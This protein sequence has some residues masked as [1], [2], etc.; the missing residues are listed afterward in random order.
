MTDQIAVATRKG[1]FLLQRRSPRNWEI[2]HV[3]FLGDAFA[4]VEPDPRDNSLY[5]A[6]NLGHFGVKLFRSADGG[7]DWTEIA[8]PAYPAPPADAPP[9]VCRMSGRPIPWKL[10]LV[11]SLAPGGA[12]QPGVLWAGTLPGGLFRSEDSGRSW[13]LVRSLWDRPERRQWTGG[14]YDYAGIHSVCVDPRDSRRVTL[15]VSTGGVWRTCDGGA[16]W[17]L[18]GR[19][20]FA[21][22]L[23]PD[24]REDPGAQDVHRLAACRAAP[25]AMWVQHHNGIFRS[26][27][28]ATTFSHVAGVKP[29][30][31]GFAVAAHP[32]DPA[33]AW[34]V[35]AVKDEKRIPVDGRLV[36]T[37][38]RDGGRTFNAL[39]DGLP[40]EPSYDLVYRHCL[41]VD[42]TGSRLVM[43]STTGG[44]WISEDGG[45]RWTPLPARLPP[46]YSVRFVG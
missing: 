11:W 15:A 12:D 3:A 43:G 34:F 9:D 40:T 44:L 1:V 4:L 28:G 26:T 16:G 33:T 19:G 35:P 36:V 24:R 7:R 17:E 22:Y 5:A 46:V 32:T 8:A 31:F 45:D 30:D 13:T 25:D 14:G 29:S 37:R 2:A 10:V 6:A 21:E 18:I 42:A 20:M 38:T 39:S 23:P 41:D 27:D